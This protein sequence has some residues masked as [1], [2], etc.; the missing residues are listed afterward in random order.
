[1]CLYVDICVCVS[2]WTYVYVSLCGDMCMCPYVEI[3]VH[4]SHV[5][6]YVYVSLCGDMCMC[7]Y[8]EI[9]VSAVPSAT[10]KRL[11]VPCSKNWMVLS[12]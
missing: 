1:M 6:I 10:R 3:Y 7:L 9:G 8:M 4:V 2:M 5:E 12:P 11:K